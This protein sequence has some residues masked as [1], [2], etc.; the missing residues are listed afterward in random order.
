LTAARTYTLPNRT[1]TFSLSGDT[2]TGDVTGTLDASGATALTIAANSVALTTDTTGNY[3]LDIVA[4]GGLTGDASGEGVT[5]T[6]AVGAGTGIIVNANDVAIDTSVVV[7]LTGTQ[8]LTNKTLTAPKFADLGFIADPNGNES[9]IFDSV[10]SAVNELTIVNSATGNG[11]ALKATGGDTDVAISF[12]AKGAGVINIGNTS[13]GSILFAGGAGSTGC[14]ITTAGALTC[15]G[16]GTFS[17]ISGTNTGDQTITLTGGV[18]GS[19]T[20]SFAATVI[21]NANLT[22]VVTSVGNATA[23]ADAALSI[24]KT[25]GLQTALDAKESALTFSTGLTRET[26]T[27]TNNLS[28]GV[29]GGQSVIGGTASGNN[30]TLS[31]TSHATKGKILFGTSAYDEVNNRLG[32]GTVSP[33]SKLTVSSTGGSNSGINLN[34]TSA[35]NYGTIDFN[36]PTGLIGQFVT[37]G[38]SY[39]NGIFIGD[40]VAL[41]GY[42]T[43][44]LTTV[45]AGGTN[46]YINFATGG[47][48]LANERMRIAS[49]GNVGIGKVSPTAVLHLKAGTATANTAPLKFTSGT[50]NTTAEAG[51]MEFLTDAWYGTITTGAVRKQFAFNPM[52]TG[53]DL[54]YGGA[55]GVE[56]RLANGTAG[57]VLQSNGTT[58]APTWATLAGGGDALVANPLSQFAQT[59][60]LQLKD[61][62]SDETGSGALVFATSPTLVT[63]LLGT[64]TSGVMTNVT[65][66]ASGLTAGNVTTNANLTG[67]VT[68]TGNA[69]AIANGAITNAMLTNGA[70]A[71]LSGTNTGD[72]TITLT[73]D[74]TGT[75]TGSFATTIGSD[76]ILESMLKAV[77]SPTDELCLTYEST[78]GDFEWQSCGVAS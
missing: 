20:G 11:V 14:T 72:Q 25:S 33:G 47:L 17:N 53:G 37:T 65:G 42:A 12:D 3:I 9:L 54:V 55:S 13:T 61:T 21:T 4:G 5:A 15:D 10:A 50:L 24:A 78:T 75:G 40:Q 67:V 36:T 59:T 18:T 77:N 23:I 35:S 26:N 48:A 74:V 44:G 68:S 49:N 7:T 46:G 56:T 45:V 71:N 73:G 6:L 52:T 28:T 70:V 63:P 8:T 76:K 66:T 16:A 30:L 60:S 2:F 51:A 19:G 62:I 43:N 69:T 32:I 41:A 34:M 64:P 1:G 22:G 38:A 27:I 57:Q 58:L 29:S 31:S 39:S